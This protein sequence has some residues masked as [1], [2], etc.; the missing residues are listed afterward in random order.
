MQQDQTKNFFYATFK[1]FFPYIYLIRLSPK[2]FKPP[3]MKTTTI[4]L[5]CV[6]VFFS[7][8]KNNTDK[9]LQANPTSDNALYSTTVSTPI[10]D[11]G[12]NK[13]MDSVGGLYPGG[14][15]KA[16]G[17]YAHNLLRFSDS[18][19]PIDT[20]GNPSATGNILFLSLG[21]STG[22]HNM[23]ALR[24]K[25]KGNPETN[26]YLKLLNG[27]NGSGEASLNSIAKPDAPYWDHV[28][29]SLTATKSSYR[30][31]QVIYLE[32]EDSSV[33]VSWPGRPI[34]VK[35]LLEAALRNI[36]I[37]FPNIKIVYVLG[38]TQTFNVVATWNKEPCPYYFGWACKWAIQ[39]Q[40]NNVPGT[41]YK[42]P[43]AVAPLLAWG[44]YQ[45]A[46]SMPRKTDGFYWLPSE[47]AD[48]LHANAEGQDTLS[49]RFQNFLLTDKYASTWY[50]NHGTGK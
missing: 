46:D 32:T 35:L 1:I 16:S 25:T 19:I 24:D 11:L 49:N 13:Y 9:L 2:Q 5:I 18:I 45:W 41:K 44:F 38:R 39:D 4:A 6:L 14:V 26:P 50:A 36:K 34:E 42:G 8:T 7:C 12:K 47:T 17:T 30:Q 28:T 15:N 23:Q 43:K 3:T 10:N 37:K 31:V 22:G 27:N 40:I 20:F 48:G 29:Y 21:G 33:N